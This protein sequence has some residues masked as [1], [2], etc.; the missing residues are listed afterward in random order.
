[1]ETLLFDPARA[2]TRVAFG[3]AEAEVAQRVQWRAAAEVFRAIEVTLR[4]AAAHPEVFIDAPFLR[5]DVTEFAERAAAADLAVRLSMA[6]GTVRTYGAVAATL[7]ER[8]PS[9]WAYFVEGE[10]S[11]QNAREASSAVI[12]LPDAAWAAFDAAIHD[13]ARTLAP[14]RFRAVVDRYPRRGS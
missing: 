10:I 13:P 4:E 5:G 12:E 9:V 8:L 2:E 11:T 14:A 7:R 6:E 3:M 1:M